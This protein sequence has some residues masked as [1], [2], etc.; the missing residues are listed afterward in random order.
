MDLRV[1]VGIMFLI[2]GIILAAYGWW[3]P[4]D[5]APRDLGL[6]VNLVWGC[7]LAIFGLAMVG[8]AAVVRKRNE[9]RK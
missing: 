4:H 3:A 6:R 7:C 9:S 1:P 8:S 5:V 2:M